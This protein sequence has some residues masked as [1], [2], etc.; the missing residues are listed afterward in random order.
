MRFERRE[1]KDK[2]S[3]KIVVIKNEFKQLSKISLNKKKK[4]MYKIQK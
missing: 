3:K 1:R 4:N 2:Y